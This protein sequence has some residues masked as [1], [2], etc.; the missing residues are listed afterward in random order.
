MIWALLRTC[1]ISMAKVR[2]FSLNLF[3]VSKIC[4]IFMKWRWLVTCQSIVGSPFLHYTREWR[5]LFSM[6]RWIV[7]KIHIDGRRMRRSRCVASSTQLLLVRSI[8]FFFAGLGNFE[9][10]VPVFNGLKDEREF[11]CYIKSDSN[12]LF[13]KHVYQ[14]EMVIY[15]WYRPLT[16]HKPVPFYR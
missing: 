7:Y 8:S 9:T 15:I 13:W 12:M 2:F 6:S 3:L 4:I 10:R 16:G 11:V 1:K 14:S 5:I